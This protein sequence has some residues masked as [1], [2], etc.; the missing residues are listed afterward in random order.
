MFEEIAALADCSFEAL[1]GDQ[2][3][4]HCL[5]KN[6]PRMRTIGHCT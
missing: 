1:E 6:E 3:H 4:S 2:D 5:V